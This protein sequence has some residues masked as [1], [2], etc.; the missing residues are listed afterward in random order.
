[1]TDSDY[2]HISVLLDRS[3][4]MSSVKEDMEGGFNNFIKEQQ[5]VPGKCRLSLFQ[6]DHA[7]EVVYVDQDIKHVPRLNLT[8]RGATAL[9][10]GLG[11]SIHETGQFLS[12]MPESQRPGKVIFM[13]IT[14]GHENS[15]REYSHLH[16]KE[17]VEKQQ[18]Q[19]NWQFAFL[20]ANID[21]IGEA[22]SLGMRAVGAMNYEANT[23]GIMHMYGAVSN[24]I[25][26]HRRGWDGGEL[27]LAP[28]ESKDSDL[29]E[30]SQ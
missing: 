8:P 19:Y 5:Q 3:G 6:F 10:D 17:M 12:Q 18:N 15:S 20:G 11:R 26:S 14:D 29:L 9:L 30:S 22:S 2:T 1:M 28:D 16:I 23:K 7:Y 25:G 27:C 4:S 13:V 21:A 24:A